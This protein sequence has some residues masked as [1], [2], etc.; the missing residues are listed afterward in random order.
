MKRSF[1]ILMI[2]LIFYFS[3]IFTVSCESNLKNDFIYGIWEG[4]HNEKNVIYKFNKGESCEFIYMN[5]KFDTIEFI[6]GNF[7]INFKNN[8]I[9]LSVK[10][11]PQLNHPLY[12]IV[13]FENSEYI[14]LANFSPKWKIRPIAFDR[15]TDIILKRKKILKGKI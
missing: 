13:N 8:P 10:N 3:N 2:L 12:T 6:Q 15:K 4:V 9:S 1:F 14:R 5:S 7:E 11:I